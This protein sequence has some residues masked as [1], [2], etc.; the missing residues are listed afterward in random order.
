MLRMNRTSGDRFAD[1]AF[2]ICMILLIVLG[3]LMPITGLIATW[4]QTPWRERLEWKP[5]R[6]NCTDLPAKGKLCMGERIVRAYGEPE[7]YYSY[8]VA[9]E[10]DASGKVIAQHREMFMLPVANE[11]CGCEVKTG[12]G[13][14]SVLRC[15]QQ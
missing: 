6:W 11:S 7:I 10:M 14:W 8:V 13:E 1:I 9:T 5:A 12:S 3:L 2:W 15:T 4:G